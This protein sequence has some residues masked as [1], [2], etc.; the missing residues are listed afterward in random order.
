[1][2]GGVA[3]WAGNCTAQ[4]GKDAYGGGGIAVQRR[5]LQRMPTVH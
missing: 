5:T 1:M 4:G 2:A 3:G